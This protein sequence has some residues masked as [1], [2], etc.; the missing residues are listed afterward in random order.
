MG[1]SPTWKC[2]NSFS[3]LYEECL[4]QWWSSW[5]ETILTLFT[6]TKW[7]DKNPA[8]HINEVETKVYLQYRRV[9]FGFCSPSSLVHYT[10]INSFNSVAITEC[11]PRPQRCLPDFSNLAN[12]RDIGSSST[13]SDPRI[14]LT[15][16]AVA[17]FFKA[18]SLAF[19][20][21]ATWALCKPA[22]AAPRLH[23]PFQSM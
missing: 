1:R 16:T 2:I 17:S 20:P 11:L 15:F 9:Q 8:H 10:D 3:K 22:N 23:N 5:H 19:T 14:F 7:P 12:F 18:S 21:I 13:I 4:K 6:G